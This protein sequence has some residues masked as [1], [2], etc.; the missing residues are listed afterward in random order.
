VEEPVGVHMMRP[1]QR[2]ATRRMMRKLER[3]WAEYQHAPKVRLSWLD[4]RRAR[5]AVS[6]SFIQ[7]NFYP[8]RSP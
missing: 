4:R 8:R 2:W 6:R 3:E 1:L 5:A 7:V